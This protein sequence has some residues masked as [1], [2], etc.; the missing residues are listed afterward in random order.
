M[1]SH[2]IDALSVHYL[3]CSRRHTV[4]GKRTL[5]ST[6]AID[7]ERHLDDI[8]VVNDYV[9]ATIQS[10]PIRDNVIEDIRQATLTDPVLRDVIRCCQSTWPPINDLPSDVRLYAHSKDHL[11]YDDG[12]LMFDERVVVL[13]ALHPRILDALHAAHQGIVKSHA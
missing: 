6:P 13:S 5:T 8:D 1:F 7:C 9:I 10:L 2:Q 12:I 4:L 3:I 11:T